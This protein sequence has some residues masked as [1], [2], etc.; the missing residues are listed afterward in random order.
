MG[1]DPGLQA[2]GYGFIYSDGRTSEWIAH[3][4]IK[5][6][7]KDNLTARLGT[8]FSQTR[9]LVI[10][11]QPDIMSLEEVFMARNPSIAIKLGHARAAVICA[12]LQNGIKTKEYSTKLIKQIVTG[13]GSAS[14]EQVA[15]MVTRLL[16]IVNRA[17][18]F[19]ATDA[20]AAALCYSHIELSGR[21]YD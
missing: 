16:N 14:K 21:R 10:Q 3:G 6:N 11:Y 4:E 17:M 1:V 20:M 12:V 9:E 15:Y 5:T 13:R 8:I 7:A 18:S 19:D 2:T